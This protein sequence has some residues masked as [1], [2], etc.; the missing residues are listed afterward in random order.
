VVEENLIEETEIQFLEYIVRCCENI[1]ENP[2]MKKQYG[3]I[4][5]MLQLYKMRSEV[6]TRLSE[7][8]KGLK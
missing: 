7:I 6:N 1:I 8:R 2:T 5:P 4:P 3:L